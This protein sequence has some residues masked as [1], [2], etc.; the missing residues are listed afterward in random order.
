MSYVIKAMLYSLKKCDTNCQLYE[1][2]KKD[3]TEINLH[4]VRNHSK[5]CHGEMVDFKNQEKV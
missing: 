5:N 1:F 2:S 4:Q 3:T